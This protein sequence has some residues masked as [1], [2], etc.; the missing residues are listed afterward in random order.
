MS[1]PIKVLLSWGFIYIK[2]PLTVLGL[3]TSALGISILNDA[4]L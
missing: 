1:V 3:S 4:Q 2:I